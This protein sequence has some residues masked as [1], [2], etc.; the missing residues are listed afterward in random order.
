[1]EEVVKLV[2]QMGTAL[3]VRED[4]HNLINEIEI[5]IEKAYRSKRR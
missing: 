2:K 5:I 3:S 1:M 4:T